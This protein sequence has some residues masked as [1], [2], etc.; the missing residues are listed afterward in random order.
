[1]LEAILMALVWP[2]VMLWV[3]ATG[4]FEHRPGDDG[5]GW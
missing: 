2:V 3:A 5:E 4:G 1:M